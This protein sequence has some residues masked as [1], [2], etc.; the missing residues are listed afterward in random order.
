MKENFILWVL[1]FVVFSWEAILGIYRRAMFLPKWLCVTFTILMLSVL[2]YCQE[3][4]FAAAQSK[5]YAMFTNNSKTIFLQVAKFLLTSRHDEKQICWV[6][7]SWRWRQW[8][9]PVNWL[10]CV[11]PCVICGCCRCVRLRCS[12]TLRSVDRYLVTD[13]S[14]QLFGPIFEGRT[15]AVFLALVTAM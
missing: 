10:I 3:F 11:R 6:I 8:V 1:E 4:L 12:G 7:S 13:V 5:Q 9:P 14:G 2:F 15:P